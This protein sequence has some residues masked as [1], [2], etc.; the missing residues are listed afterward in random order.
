MGEKWIA[1]IGSPRMGKNT[2]LIVD[3]VIEGL[4]ELVVV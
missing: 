1:V 2:D 4:N 3:Y